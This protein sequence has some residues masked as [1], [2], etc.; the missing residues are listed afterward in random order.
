MRSE[1]SSVLTTD[2]DC[3]EIVFASSPK[4]LSALDNAET[5]TSSRLGANEPIEIHVEPEFNAELITGSWELVQMKIKS[6]S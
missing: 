3:S 1:F 4:T 2:P 5:D 6:Q